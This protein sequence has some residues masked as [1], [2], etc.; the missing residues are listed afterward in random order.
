MEDEKVAGWLVETAMSLGAFAAEV[1]TISS[2]ELSIEVS[3]QEIETIKMADHAGVGIRIIQDGRMGFAYNSSF[4]RQS[5]M[6]M[7]KKAIANA[8]QATPDPYHSFPPADI[9]RKIDIFDADLSIISLEEKIN[10]AMEIERQVRSFDA[11]IKAVENCTYQDTLIRVCL[12]N[13]KGISGSYQGTYCGAFASVVAEQDGDNQTGFG[14]QYAHRFKCLDPELVGREAAFRAVRMLG[15]G[16][17]CT[18]KT[19]VLLE[20]YVAA[21]LLGTMGQ[22]LSAEAVQKGRS[23]FAKKLN[24]KVASSLINVIDD[25][26]L[27]GGIH[28]TPFDAEGVPARRT[29]LI[30]EGVLQ[31]YLHN[32][33]TAARDGVASTGNSVRFSF[34]GPP[35]VGMTNIFITPGELSESQLIKELDQ[36]FYITDIMGLHT[37]NPITGDF[38]VGAAGLLIENGE[39]TKPIRGVAIA[40]N[41]MELFE[42]I[43]G[44]GNNLR[45]FGGKGSPALRVSRLALSGT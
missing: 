7:L 10:L 41:M 17:T 34:K 43:D 19:A 25:G 20:P 3:N 1:F 8:K 44:I 5:L 28:T 31:G 2:Q 23:L 4:G 37:A 12:S 18:R 42:L 27:A 6:E 14:I 39:L 11:R 33:Y 32:T 26:T 36:G 24:T 15:A 45:F 22:A 9:C 35:Q 40:G 38:S 21:S 16:T 30:K 13:S 29:S